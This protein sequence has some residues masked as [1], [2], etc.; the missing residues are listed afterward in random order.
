MLYEDDNR[1]G[2]RLLHF[3]NTD[4]GRHVSASRA[5]ARPSQRQS[6]TDRGTAREWNRDGDDVTTIAAAGART[7]GAHAA[8]VILKKILTPPRSA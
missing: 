7:L 1:G 2:G 5:G 6:R 3:L 4:K 8:L